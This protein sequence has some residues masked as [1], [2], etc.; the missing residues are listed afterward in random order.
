M[1]RVDVDLSV[2]LGDTVSGDL[3]RHRDPRAV[4][5]QDSMFRAQPHGTCS[6][7]LV[8]L[9]SQPPVKNYN[10]QHAQHGAAHPGCSVPPGPRGASWF[11]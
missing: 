2:A 10:T 8:S 7:P 5:T 6:F 4:F 1:E 9:R 11:L 3:G